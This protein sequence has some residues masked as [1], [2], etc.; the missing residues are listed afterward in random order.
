MNPF[1]I[2]LIFSL[3]KSS[4]KF[5]QIHEKNDDKVIDTT[6]QQF[7]DCFEKLNKHLFNE[8]LDSVKQLLYKTNKKIDI[9]S[10]NFTEIL[11]EIC[12][13]IC[14][15]YISN[16]I[17]KDYQL[18]GDNMLF[19]Y[20]GELNV[21]NFSKKDNITRFNIIELF[22][23]FLDE[24][25]IEYSKLIYK[26]ACDSGNLGEYQKF[27]D[28]IKNVWPCE[29]NERKQKLQKNTETDNKS[30]NTKFENNIDNESKSTQSIVLKIKVNHINILYEM[31]SLTSTAIN[32]KQ[33][34]KTINDMNLNLLKNKVK[35]IFCDLKEIRDMVTNEEMN[36]DLP[37]V[38]KKNLS[39]IQEIKNNFEM[40]VNIFNELESNIKDIFITREE[41]PIVEY[42]ILKQH[43]DD[44]FTILFKNNFMNSV[45]VIIKLMFDKQTHIEK[46]MSKDT[47]LINAEIKHMFGL[48][49]QKF[50]NN[51]TDHFY[52]KDNNTDLTKAA[53]YNLFDN[54]KNPHNW[55]KGV[56]FD[57]VKN[58]EYNSKIVSDLNRIPEV[59]KDIK[60]NIQMDT[61]EINS[62][63]KNDCNKNKK[64][65]SQTRSHKVN[66]ISVSTHYKEATT[67][68]ENAAVKFIMQNN[69]PLRKI[70]SINSSVEN[71]GGTESNCQCDVHRKNDKNISGLNYAEVAK[72]CN[73][74]RELNEG[75]LAQG[76]NSPDDTSFQPSQEK[77][78]TNNCSGK[79]KHI[80]LSAQN[81]K[82]VLKRPQNND[83]FE[84]VKAKNAQTIEFLSGTRN[85]DKINNKALYEKYSKKVLEKNKEENKTEESFNLNK[86]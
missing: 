21:K 32:S 72:I 76:K 42:S 13:E 27:L 64:N 84:K 47:T 17:F 50:G 53:D 16:N 33:D 66:L 62:E 69:T 56:I 2:C 71:S 34:I 63:T 70:N 44:E 26:L 43:K 29:T 85:I 77:Q 23:E 81:K 24:F 28:F 14:K 37:N 8:I 79:D 40:P 7:K 80:D 58:K 38:I 4:K 60:E 22:K 31:I 12:T 65:E 41:N 20:T 18:I 1:I 35:Q 83:T 73:T 25:T 45:L 74:E 49:I 68:S 78:N 3:I 6:E 10:T 51:E 46:F 11:N 55:L 36:L 54:T 48:G 9:K 19:A 75:N 5:K 82:E 86:R 15:V 61:N 52:K 39:S 57:D 30:E 67:K 59:H